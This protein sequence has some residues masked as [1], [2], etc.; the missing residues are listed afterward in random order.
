MKIGVYT[1]PHI[2]R[3]IN[4]LPD[5]TQNIVDTFRDMY[6]IFKLHDVSKVVCCGDFFDKARILSSDIKLVSYVMGVLADSELETVV[7]SGNHDFGDSKDSIAN[8]LNTL[9]NVT[10]VSRFEHEVVQDIDLIYIPYGSTLEEESVHGRNIIF[11]HEEYAGMII[12]TLG[13]KSRS[14]KTVDKY[15][16]RLVVNG[17]IHRFSQDTGFLNL[18]TCIPT[19]FG[20]QDFRSLP[21]VAIIDTDNLKYI[22]EPLTE[23]YRFYI[24]SDIAS[25]VDL[26][27]KVSEIHSDEQC[28]CCIRIDHTCDTEELSTVDLS[29]FKYVS[30]RK[31]IPESSSLETQNVSITG[32]AQKVNV[33]PFI[34]TR[35]NGDKELSDTSKSLILKEVMNTLRGEV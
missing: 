14:T 24:L 10:T 33:V 1:D 32:S 13:T 31:V 18:G 30:Y 16:G 6:G 11:S 12:N 2:T 28:K 25:A 34:E 29:G 19:K 21:C 26:Q 9:P 27:S 17:H 5:R 4:Y 8:I 23:P 15:E 7:L 22:L 35:V 20:E 3:K